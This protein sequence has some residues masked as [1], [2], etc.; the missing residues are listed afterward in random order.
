MREGDRI[1]AERRRQPMYEVTGE[2]RFDGP[3]EW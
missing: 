1:A 2:Y 3:V